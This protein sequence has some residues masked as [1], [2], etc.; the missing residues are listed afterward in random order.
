MWNG[1]VC[2]AVIDTVTEARIIDDYTGSNQ[3]AS[4]TPDWNT[5]PDNDD[6]FTIYLPE[7]RQYPTTNLAAISNAAV[8]TSTAQLGVNVVNFGGSAGTFSG[9]RPEV[10]TSYIAG[11]AV[12]TSTAQ[13]GVNVVNFGGSAGTFSGGRPEVNTSYWGGTVVGSAYVRANTLQFN[14][15]T[16]TCSGGV[17]IQ[18]GTIASQADITGLQSSIDGLYSNPM[19]LATDAVSSSS[20]ATSAVTEMVNAVW[21][22]TTRTLTAATNVTSTGGTVPITAGGYVSADI[23]AIN[24]VTVDGAGTSGDPWGPV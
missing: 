23:K 13:I 9:G 6:T 18:T 11:S 22:N 21:A 10:N 8:S 1:C 4:V 14:G 24:A 7:G 2:V 16:I 12:S 3:Q 15:Q 20:L 5:A 19:S 17:T